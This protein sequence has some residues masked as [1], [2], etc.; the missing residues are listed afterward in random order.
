MSTRIGDSRLVHGVEDE[1]WGY[2]QNIKEVSGSKKSEAPNGAGNTVSVE[3]S[4]VG[5]KKVTGTYFYL[6][7]QTGGP[8]NLVGSTTGVTITDVTGTIYVDN[9]GKT[10]SSGDWCMID[11]EGTVYPFLVLS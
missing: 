8:L 6:S 2:V 7:D 4:N 9:A 10:R 1:V 11:F 5:E 3:F